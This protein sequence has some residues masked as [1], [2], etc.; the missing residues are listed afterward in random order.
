MPFVDSRDLMADAFEKQKPRQ[1][2]WGFLL[3]GLENHGVD[4]V[5]I[6]PTTSA[7]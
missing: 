3:P 7:L 6:E 5:G 2:C 1:N 4:A